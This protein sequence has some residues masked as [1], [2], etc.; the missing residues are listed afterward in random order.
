MADF[1]RALDLALDALARRGPPGG[2]ALLAEMRP[3]LLRAGPVPRRGPLTH[4]LIVPGEA[5]GANVFE[6]GRG[7]GLREAMLDHAA[8]M[9]QRSAVEALF[10]RPGTTWAGGLLQRREGPRIKLYAV[11]PEPQR[12]V[13]ITPRGEAR[14]RSYHAPFP[15]EW[16]SVDWPPP[17]EAESHRLITVLGD[18]KRTLNVIFRPGAPLAPLLRLGAP[19]WLAE[20]DAALA[21]LGFTSRS[22]AWE[23]D[24]HADGR[25]ETDALI[26]I[27]AE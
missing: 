9:G 25:V 24:L 11:S 8:R 10:A 6:H 15:L 20:L 12:G 23:L 27:G 22:V 5:V 4:D 18:E 3:L 14:W 1:S 2:A 26:A 7:L 16:P 21:P 19:S 17:Q 13:D